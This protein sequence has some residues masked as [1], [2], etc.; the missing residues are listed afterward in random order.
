[1]DDRLIGRSDVRSLAER[2]EPFGLTLTATH[3]LVVAATDRPITS[4][5]P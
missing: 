5:C 4:A 3:V 1:V 2:A